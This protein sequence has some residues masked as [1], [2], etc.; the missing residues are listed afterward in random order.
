MSAWNALLKHHQKQLGTD[1]KVTR[2][3][4]KP[5]QET[6]KFCMKWLEDSG[7]SVHIIESKA[8]YSRSAGRYLSGQ[9]VSGMSDCVGCTPHG[10][11]AFIEFKAK[12]K[13]STLK[14]H[15]RQFLKDKI[16]RGCFAVVVD[17]KELLSQYYVKWN[18]IEDRDEKIAFLLEILPK[19]KSSEDFNID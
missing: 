1:K 3:N 17:S 16:L 7:F 11:G 10:I 15:Q 6:V 4:K 2:K 12:G 8:V 18:I 9:T 5:E 13:C 14:P 19:E